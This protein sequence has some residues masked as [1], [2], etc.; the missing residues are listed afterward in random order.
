MPNWILIIFGLSVVIM[1]VSLGFLGLAFYKW[2][3]LVV[4][5]K[6]VV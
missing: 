6:Y 4:P 3:K 5:Q 2:R 1:I